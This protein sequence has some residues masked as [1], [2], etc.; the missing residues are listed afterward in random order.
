MVIDT[1]YYNVNNK[2]SIDSSRQII[3]AKHHT[4]VLIDMS[5]VTVSGLCVIYCLALSFIAITLPLA[6][7]VAGAG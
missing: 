1:I 5:A 2:F 7:V 6:G 3:R 4:V